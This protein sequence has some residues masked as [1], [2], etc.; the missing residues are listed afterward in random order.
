VWGI[1]F[2]SQQGKAVGEPFRVTSFDSPGKIVWPKLGGADI[3]LSV[4]RLVLPITEVTGNIW[5]MDGVDR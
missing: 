4:D 1:R 2:D 5:M 3:T